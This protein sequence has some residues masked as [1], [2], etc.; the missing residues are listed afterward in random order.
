MPDLAKATPQIDNWPAI[1][2]PDWLKPR[3][4]ARLQVIYQNLIDGLAKKSWWVKAGL[5]ALAWPLWR[6]ARPYLAS[7]AF[8]AVHDALD[9]KKLLR[10]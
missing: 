1:E 5:S 7:A 9:E 3:I 2:M 8:D 6:V 10:P 4:E